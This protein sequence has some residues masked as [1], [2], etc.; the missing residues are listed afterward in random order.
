MRKF[1]TIIPFLLI[2]TCIYSQQLS[3]FTF[4]GGAN[5]SSIS[6]LTD[7]G[8]LIRITADGKVIEW[9]MEVKSDRYEYY[10]PKLQP[11][12]GRV[13]YYGPDVDSA[14][15]GKIKSIGTCI[16]TYYGHY[17]MEEKV[18]KIKSVGTLPLDYFSN[19]ENTVIKGKLRSVGYVALEYYS[20]FEN[21]AYRGKLKSVGNTS[22]TYYSSFDDK[23]IIGK[24]KSIGSFTYKWPTSYQGRVYKSEMKPGWQRQYINGIIYIIR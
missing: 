17:E 14:F 24:L 11:Y 10:A 15:R 3:Q 20:S 8:V 16:L 13:D 19:F 21:E 5:L 9:G 4:S 2:V 22:I 18:G 1:F 12:M 23:F 7:Q 6:F